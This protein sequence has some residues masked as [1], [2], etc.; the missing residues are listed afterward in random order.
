[1]GV[2][3]LFSVK[4]KTAIVTGASYGLGVTF[5]EALA[6]GGANVVLADRSADK[7]D[8][9][10]RHIQDCGGTAVSHPCN[11]AESAAVTGLVEAAWQRF[12]RVDVL[13]NNAGVVAEGGFMP[14][15]ISDEIFR[16]TI[17]TNLMGTWYGCREVGRRMLQDGKGGSI[18]NV[19]SVAG[20]AGN[21]PIPAAYQ[22]SKAAVINLARNLAL[23]WGSRGVRVNALAPGWFP[24]EMTNPY[25]AIPAFL[26][27]AKTQAAMGRIGDP[28]ELI[29]AV[30]YL[31]SEA[32]SFVTG[33]VLAVDGGLSASQGYMPLGEEL[34][35]IFESFPDGVG[36]RIVA[37]A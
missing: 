32:S 6:E 27:R 36:Q 29:G 3:D 5:A 11:V 25:F 19:A 4:G 21:E 2:Y 33:Q 10:A 34:Y 26:A 14:E 17:E 37:E 9:V 13:V 1:V 30:L 28:K 8:A 12:G 16:Q 31:A 24:S 35:T 7:L 22:A 15:H 18:I 23:H 20:L